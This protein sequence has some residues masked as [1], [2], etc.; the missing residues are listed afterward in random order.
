MSSFVL[1]EGS[2]IVFEP[3]FGTRQVV[4]LAPATMVGNGEATIGGRRMCV[5]GDEKRMQWQ[6]QYFIPGYT[7]G[8]G[9]VSIELLDGSQMAPCVMSGTPLIL[10]GQQFTARF[11]PSAP[12]VMSAPP[13]AVDPTF[14]SM[15]RGC[16]MPP[17]TSVSA[18]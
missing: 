6:A 15:G 16:F 5:V 8:A 13:Y 11:S 9:L 4:L 12:A 1:I 17:Q 7:P 2:T 14:P 10:V 3:M 18:G